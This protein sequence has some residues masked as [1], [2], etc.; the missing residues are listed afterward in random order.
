MAR[1]AIWTRVGKGLL[2]SRRLAVPKIY[3]ERL[4]RSV[5]V[6]MVVEWYGSGGKCRRN[7]GI[8]EIDEAFL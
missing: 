3:L 6:G 4:E 1:R 2:A 8:V 5:G 7:M